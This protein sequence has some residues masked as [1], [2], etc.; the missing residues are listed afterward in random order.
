M[1]ITSWRP[2]GEQTEAIFRHARASCPIS[3]FPDGALK[4]IPPELVACDGRLSRESFRPTVADRERNHVILETRD[5]TPSRQVKI[6]RLNPLVG[7]RSRAV[8]VKPEFIVLRLIQG[9]SSSKNQPLAPN[10][11]GSLTGRERTP[12][13]CGP[14]HK[15]PRNLHG[16]NPAGLKYC[17]GRVQ[18]RV[19]CRRRDKGRQSGRRER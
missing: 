9:S 10:S 11:L 12:P 18:L 16:S 15:N 14:D 17:S 4:V 3:A 5:Y 19:A 2:G 6:G 13:G 7:L 8:T 1:N